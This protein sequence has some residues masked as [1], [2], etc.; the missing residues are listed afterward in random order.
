MLAKQKTK[1]KQ[2]DGVCKKSAEGFEGKEKE[3]KGS[4]CGWMV[5]MLCKLA[6]GKR[7]LSCGVVAP[8]TALGLWRR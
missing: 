2:D 7:R 5:F 8:I 6:V 4:G 1:Q 3:K